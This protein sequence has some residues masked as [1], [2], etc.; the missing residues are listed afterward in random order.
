MIVDASVVERQDLAFEK[1]KSAMS[2]SPILVTP[3][4]KEP[5]ELQ[6]DACDVGLGA[7]LAQKHGTIAYASRRLKGPE[8]RWDTREKEAFACV[9]ACEHF[10]VYLLHNRFVLRTD[11]KA[12]EY[13]MNEKRNSKLIRW[14]LRLQEYEFEIQHIPGSH[15]VVADCLSRA[16]E[17]NMLLSEDNDETFRETLKKAQSEDSQCKKILSKISLLLQYYVVDS[18]GIL[19]RIITE[20]RP[21]RDGLQSTRIVLPRSMLRDILDLHH[22]SAIGGHQG[23]T[24][25]FLKI[26]QAYY[27]DGLRRAV[28]SYIRGC[29]LC[30]KRK[31]TLHSRQGLLKPIITTEAFHTVSMDLMG[32]L[33][34]KYKHLIVFVD[35]FTRWIEAAPITNAKGHAVAQ[36]FIDCI[37]LRH[38]CPKQILT[39]RGKCFVGKFFSNVKRILG[40]KHLT[41][42]AYRPQTNS[43]VER[44]NRV[45]AE[46]I[47]SYLKGKQEEWHRYVNP[48][49]FAHRTSVLTKLHESPFY[50]L[51]HR[52]PVFPEF[53]IR[54]W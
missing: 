54:V 51:Y 22:S 46:A 37:I 45:I 27:M 17:I 2:T 12:L 19:R 1:M 47:T 7:V 29:L 41:T 6:V 28:K 30:Q 8:T 50:L 10:R 31:A 42:S 16:V 3:D 33:P 36:A 40:I 21:A 48:V 52:D 5:F 23:V 44:Q 39:D 14:S 43:R 24:R 15:N 26:S 35:H 32:P 13:L 53:L 11:H 49:L 38:G 18:Y 9:W 20:N 4:F 25:T 34:G